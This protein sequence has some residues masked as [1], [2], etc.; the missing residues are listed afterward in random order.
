MFMLQIMRKLLCTHLGHS[1]LLHMCKLLQSENTAGLGATLLRGAVFH[2]SMGMWGR[3]K[4]TS[5]HTT[6]AAVLPSFVRALRRSKNEVVAYEIVL[7]IRR[8][9]TQSPEVITDPAWDCVLDILD[10]AVSQAHAVLAAEL[11]GA[12]SDIETQHERGGYRGDVARFFSLIESVS[13]ARP[14]RMALYLILSL[15][16]MYLKFF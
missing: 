3:Q 2:I 12:I 5:L 15:H 7:C 11:H 9:V 16:I 6:T 13:T 1:A 10:E 4:V 14:V 8:L